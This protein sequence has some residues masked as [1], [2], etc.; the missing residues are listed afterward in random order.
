MRAQPTPPP[1]PCARRASGLCGRVAVVCR[2]Y[3]FHVRAS[4]ILTTAL[5]KAVAATQA[6]G[7]AGRGV[8]GL[9]GDGDQRR[10]GR[11]RGSGTWPRAPGDCR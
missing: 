5:A 4:P 6:H 8:C 9:G 11:V 7:P 1:R 10:R 3:E 2:L